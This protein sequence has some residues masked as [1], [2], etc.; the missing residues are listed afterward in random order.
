MSRVTGVML[1]CGSYEPAVNE[2][3]KWLEARHRQSLTDVADH[4]GG[5]KHPQFRAWCGGINHLESDEDGFA[6]FV[7][8]RTWEGPETV[9]LI[10]QPEEGS[11]R[12]YRPDRSVSAP[13]DHT[14][15]QVGTAIFDFLNGTSNPIRWH[16]FISE[17]IMDAEL[18]SIR[19]RAR[20]LGEAQ[21]VA[22]REVLLTLLGEV[23]TI[24]LRASS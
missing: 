24:R 18:E 4:A 11:T 2:V 20:A 3:C 15:E 22:D 5:P 6:E 1:I 19:T 17:P 23:E 13:Y 9:I 7:L 8:S 21:S 12:V 14:P 10:L 16:C